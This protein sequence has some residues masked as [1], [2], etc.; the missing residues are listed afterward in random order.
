MGLRE[1][2]FG[3]TVLLATLATPA[4]A[5]E[6]G[7]VTAVGGTVRWQEAREASGGKPALGAPAGLKPFVKLR[8]GDRLL[9]DAAS[10]LQVVYF[11]SARQESW[12]GATTL[13]VGT[14]ASRT[15]SGGAQ[16]EVK[17]LPAIL[18]KQL[19]RTP[20]PDGSVK[21]GMIRTRS[22]Q[23]RESA[24]NVEKTYAELRRDAA[25][26][27]LN[28][29]L[30][31]LSAWL[32]LR[33]YERVEGLLKALREKSPADPQVAALAELYG[34]ALRVARSEGK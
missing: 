13:E 2:V 9:L 28:P 25:S 7:L 15:V 11:E 10:R 29:E 1:S 22:L 14:G 34:S 21:A 6:V 26:G 30:Y 33:E 4:A 32:D 27:D 5:A 12:Q 18:V 24:A 23:P 3:W 16:P 20:A 17:T 31:A 19:T 8:E